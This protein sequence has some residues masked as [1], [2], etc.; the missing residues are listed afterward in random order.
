MCLVS[1]IVEHATDNRKTEERYLYQIPDC[2]CRL[3]ARTLPFQGGED[4][5]KPFGSTILKCI[6]LPTQQVPQQRII[7]S[8]GQ[9]LLRLHEA[10]RR[11]W[12]KL[13]CNVFDKQVRGRHGRAGLKLLFLSNILVC[14]NMVIPYVQCYQG[15]VIGRYD[16]SGPIGRRRI[17]I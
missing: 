17:L 13:D 8:D 5:S 3:L 12:N 14:F 9:A 7:P 6:R 4:G 10:P 16:Y 1:S 15:I 2:S 11:C